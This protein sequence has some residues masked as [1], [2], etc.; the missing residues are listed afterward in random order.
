MPSQKQM[1]KKKINMNGIFCLRQ[2]SKIRFK[3]FPFYMA[4][5]KKITKEFEIGTPPT[6]FQT[7]IHV[8]KLIPY[9]VY[10]RS[11]TCYE[12]LALTN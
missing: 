8:V 5:N 3:K 6:N 7:T 4:N 1:L 9:L 10:E 11:V 12:Q 2:N